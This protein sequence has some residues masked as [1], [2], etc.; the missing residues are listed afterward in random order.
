MVSLKR[1]MG[2]VVRSWV[3]EGRI[4]PFPFRFLKGG[5]SGEKLLDNMVCEKGPW[6]EPQMQASPSVTVIQCLVI[7]KCHSCL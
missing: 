1:A 4:L 3:S 5:V 7:L 6:S 2:P